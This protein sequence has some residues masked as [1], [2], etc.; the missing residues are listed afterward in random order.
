MYARNFTQACRRL[1]QLGA[2]LD[3]TYYAVVLGNQDTTT[4]QY[5]QNYNSS[6]IT[7]IILRRTPKY[8]VLPSGVNAQVVATGYTDTQVFEGDKIEDADGLDYLVTSVI[9]HGVGDATAHYECDLAMV[10]PY[11]QS[12]A[13]Y[14]YPDV[15]ATGGLILTVGAKEYSALEIICALTTQTPSNPQ[16]ATL[17]IT[18]TD[19]LSTPSNPQSATCSISTTLSTSVV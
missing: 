6:T 12:A 2:S 4:G 19:S 10:F 5:A 15:P 7:M 3:V 9:Q 1:E 16:S 17:S 8:V 18:L 13:S 11:T 14:T